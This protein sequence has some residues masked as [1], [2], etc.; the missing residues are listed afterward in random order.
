MLQFP[1]FMI[2]SGPTWPVENGSVIGSLHRVS[3]YALQLIKKMQNENIHSWTPRQDITRR[4]NRFHE[5][6]QEWINHTVWKD[7]CNSWYRNNE[8][9][10]VN[11]VWPGSSMPYQ[12]VIEQRRY[13]DLEIEYFF[14]LL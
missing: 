3:D 10:Q 2:F 6:A 14:K 4:L 5:H 1:N 8:T 11:A 9:G 7:N 13:E 12:Q